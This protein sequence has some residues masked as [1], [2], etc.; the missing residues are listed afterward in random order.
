MN[1]QELNQ[2]LFELASEIAM[3]K[4]PQ[5]WFNLEIPEVER[6]VSISDL[7]EEMRELIG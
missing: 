7:E 3:L 5:C 6:V 4:N 2:R 1:D